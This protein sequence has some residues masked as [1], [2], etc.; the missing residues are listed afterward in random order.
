MAVEWEGYLLGYEGKLL[1]AVVAI[2]KG[3]P[4]VTYQVQ[5]IL[6]HR[7]YCQE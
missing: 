1:L 7:S 3:D 4:L 6:T 5:H 2:C